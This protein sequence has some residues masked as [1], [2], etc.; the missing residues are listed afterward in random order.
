MSIAVEELLTVRPPGGPPTIPADA[1]PRSRRVSV[2]VDDVLTGCLQDILPQA[3][4]GILHG[5]RRHITWW[6]RWPS[7]MDF[8]PPPEKPRDPRRGCEAA[9][10]LHLP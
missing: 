6:V 3:L 1:T 10:T 2:A 7:R 4:Q 8:A 9:F 5:E